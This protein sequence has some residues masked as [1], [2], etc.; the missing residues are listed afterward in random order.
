MDS[1]KFNIRWTKVTM[2]IMQTIKLILHSQL[3]CCYH[4]EE[5]ILITY[6]ICL[7]N[8]FGH[9]CRLTKKKMNQINRFERRINLL[10]IKTKPTQNM[11]S[12][13]TVLM[14]TSLKHIGCDLQFTEPNE[15][16]RK[17]YQIDT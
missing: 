10:T 6:S 15:L 16:T 12:T 1:L 17:K 13:D 11:H 7:Y 5:N 9:K 8:I 2:M 4:T 3:H 14:Y